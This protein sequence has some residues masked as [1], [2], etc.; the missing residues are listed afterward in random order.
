[1]IHP[2]FDAKPFEPF[3]L[4]ELLWTYFSSLLLSKHTDKCLPRTAHTY[5]E[6]FNKWNSYGFFM[7][8]YEINRSSGYMI[9]WMDLWLISD[10]N[11]S[12]LSYIEYMIMQWLNTSATDDKIRC[13]V[14]E[15]MRFI[16]EILL[17]WA[18]DHGET[19]NLSFGFDSLQSSLLFGGHRESRASRLSKTDLWS[20]LSRSW[21]A[22]ELQS[23]MSLRTVTR[24]VRL[25]LGTRER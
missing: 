16:D 24:T 15:W 7:N 10:L 1:M 13:L 11:D 20:Q 2:L 18:D 3:W 8:G 4:Y 9:Q 19:K 21:V 17:I 22:V 14:Q 23:R 12:L 25:V 6:S 5:Y